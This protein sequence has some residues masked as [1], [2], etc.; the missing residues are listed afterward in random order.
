MSLPAPS[1]DPRSAEPA[2]S[3]S[4]AA[5]ALPRMTAMDNAVGTTAAVRR[6]AQ[7]HRRL[8][9]AVIATVVLAATLPGLG[10]HGRHLMSPDALPGPRADVGPDGWS[11]AL[12]VVG[13]AV[14]VLRRSHP[15]PVWA[16]TVLTGVLSVLH[17]GGS[18]VVA[19]PACLALYTIGSTAAVRSTVA[20]TAATAGVFA[21]ATAV[22]RGAWL[23]DRGDL[24][25]LSLMA[26][27]GAAAAVG[28][29]VRNQR[30]AL[31]AAEARARQA[32]LTREEEAERR[33]TD[34]R[35]R[36]AR[37]LHD[38]L[39]HHISVINVQAG[40]A[41]H[42][43]ATDP[44]QARTALGLVR[45]ASKTV[46]AEMSSAVGLLRTREEDAPI[47]PTPGLADVGAL[48]ESLRRAGLRLT[49]TSTGHAY[50]LPPVQDL[51]AY[52]VVQ[53]S[54]T[55]AVKYGDGTA[56]LVIDHRPEGI[57]IEVRNPVG[58]QVAAATDGGHGLIGMRER[59][60][61]VHGRLAAGP[62]A[63]G[64]FCVLAEI[65]RDRA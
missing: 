12:L 47:E 42:L 5:A 54:L 26:F 10:H 21:V 7:D 4:R 27:C 57:G 22:A 37:E 18:P 63:G 39:A 55:N 23:D 25:A 41:R 53:E 60:D 30:A 56:D 8:L 11:V 61:A 46:L 6:W 20:A 65:P 2:H 31:E 45:D 33:V 3:G 19:V 50:A 32:E 59:V 16:V 13:A 15:F 49:C 64:T 9:D 35:V 29:A 14:L 51:T 34:E 48:V 17:S 40:V 58:G 38:I 43:M 62:G 1:G 24:P 36:I 28:V 44:D 52:R